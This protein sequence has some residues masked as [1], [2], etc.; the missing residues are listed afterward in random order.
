MAVNL[1]NKL[2]HFLSCANNT[3]LA[4]KRSESEESASPSDD[5]LPA[6]LPG[7]SEESRR[8]NIESAD[9]V[10]QL[11]NLA[12]EIEGIILENPWILNEC[13][14]QHLSTDFSGEEIRKKEYA[15]DDASCCDR[16]FLGGASR[17][18]LQEIRSTLTKVKEVE[19]DAIAMYNYLNPHEQRSIS[20]CRDCVIL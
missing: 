16:F 3:V 4:L 15:E 8:A 18:T 19:K 14:I 20:C 12:R 1:S 9:K 5:D 13:S 11:R 6:P 17:A 10:T 2:N 7:Y